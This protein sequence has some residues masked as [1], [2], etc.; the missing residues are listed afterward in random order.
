VSVYGVALILA[1]FGAVLVSDFAGWR[2]SGARSMAERNTSLPGVLREWAAGTDSLEEDERKQNRLLVI[3]GWA[4]LLAAG[5]FVVVG[6]T[7]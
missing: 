3:G 1:A 4:L 5:V 6:L 2:S 7:R